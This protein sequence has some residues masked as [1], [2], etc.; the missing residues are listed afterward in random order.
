MELLSQVVAL[1]ALAVVAIQQ[2]LK[3]N[4]IPI[5]FANKYPV[6]TNILLSIGASIFIVWQNIL[7]TPVGKSEWLLLVAV[8]SVVAAITYNNLL[9]NWT[10]LRSLEGTGKK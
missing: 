6:V 7:K 9:R 8:I 2:I 1:S 4:I 5:A 3:L 10:E